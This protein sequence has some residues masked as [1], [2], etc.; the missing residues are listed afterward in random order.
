MILNICMI[1]VPHHG[2]QSDVQ[3]PIRIDVHS[4][5]WTNATSYL[6]GSSYSCGQMPSTIPIYVL[7]WTILACICIKYVLA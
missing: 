5:V 1:G 4:L 7:M 3:M 6:Q 2:F